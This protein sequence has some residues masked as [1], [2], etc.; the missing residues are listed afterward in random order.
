MNGVVREAGFGLPV[1]E[2]TRV[3]NGLT[4]VIIRWGAYFLVVV[5]DG[6]TF[7]VNRDMGSF[8]DGRRA[9]EEGPV[10]LGGMVHF[11]VHS[12]EACKGAIKV[13]EIVKVT[14]NM[15][16]VPGDWRL[17]EGEIDGVDEIKRFLLR[18]G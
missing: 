13:V 1:L 15:L 16:G 14:V 11:D 7:V 6:P 8:R 10:G 18:V 12:F 3:L 9:M 4:K 5:P 2:S 17:L